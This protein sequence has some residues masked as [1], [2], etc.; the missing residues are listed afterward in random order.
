MHNSLITINIKGNRFSCIVSLLHGAL[1][2]ILQGNI[3]STSLCNISFFLKT[4]PLT[5]PFTTLH[6]NLVEWSESRGPGM[7]SS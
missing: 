5:R 1:L 7:P 3:E 6:S 4:H 2:T